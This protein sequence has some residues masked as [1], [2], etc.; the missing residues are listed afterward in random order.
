MSHREF[1]PHIV[2]CLAV[3]R[4][5]DAEALNRRL[6]DHHTGLPRG[7]VTHPQSGPV[8]IHGADAPAAVPDWLDMVWAR[9]RLARV[10]VT[11]EATD[12]EGMLT[13]D[14]RAV[15]SALGMTWI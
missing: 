6:C 15:R 4:G 3:A 7:R 14:L 13:A 8:V 9:F 11:A 5:R 10:A 1:W 2:Q 12:H